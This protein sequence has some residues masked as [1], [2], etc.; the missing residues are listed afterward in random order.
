MNLLME[1]FLSEIN[2]LR[3]RIN[4]DLDEQVKIRQ[5]QIDGQSQVLKELDKDWKEYK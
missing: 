2:Q 3:R 1:Q 5:Q 4:E